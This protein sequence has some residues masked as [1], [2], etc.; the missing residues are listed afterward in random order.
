M[1]ANRR[2]FSAICCTIA[3][4]AAVV[5]GTR[6]AQQDAA[7]IVEAWPVLRWALI[8]LVSAILGAI[9]LSPSLWEE[10]GNDHAD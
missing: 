5:A 10:E 4:I 7:G 6:I 3:A 9:S 8:S 1:N 2:I